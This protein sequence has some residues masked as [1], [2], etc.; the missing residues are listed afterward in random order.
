M[1]NILVVAFLLMF[2]ST[3][4]AFA[5]KIATC[6][7]QVVANKSI[8]LKEAFEELQKGIAPEQSRLEKE[9]KA[10]ETAAAALADP[11][12][13]Q[14]Q[15]EALVARQEKYTSD[16]TSLLTQV[17]DA[18]LQVRVEM[19]NLILEGTKEFA[20]R[21]GFDLV[22]DTMNVLF[23][24][25]SVKTVDV[26]EDVLKEVDRLWMEAKKANAQQ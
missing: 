3:S 15:R 23:Q 19:D 9:R 11:K 4:T 10:I 18:E 7:L 26:T 21:E 24:A 14:K 22:L 8:A 6:D 16:F 20:K 13:S 12:S 17:K 25:D 5:E 2:A 1:R